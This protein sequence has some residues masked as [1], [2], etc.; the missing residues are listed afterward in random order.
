[1]RAACAFLFY[2]TGN[3]LITSAMENA[4]QQLQPPVRPRR[5]SNMEALRVLAMFFV[6]VVHADFSALGYPNISNLTHHPDERIVMSLV[7]YLSVVCVDVFVMISGWFGIRARAK[8]VARLLFQ[9]FFVTTIVIAGFAVYKGGLPDTLEKLWES[10]FGY[11]F[12]YAYLMLY[13]LSPVLNAFVERATQREFLGVLAAFFIVQTLGMRQL[14]GI[15]DHG[16]STLS[17]IGLYLL[18]R[19]LRL[20]VA[21]RET[22]PNVVLLLGYVG[23]AMLQL[24]IM[25][26]IAVGGDK[27]CLHEFNQISTNYTNP[28]I[29]IGAAFLLLFFSRLNFT[30]RIINWLAAGSLSVYVFHQNLLARPVFK[31]TVQHLHSEHG[32]LAFAG[33]TFLFLV[34]VYLMAVLIDQLR[35]WAWQAAEVG[36]QKLLTC[37]QARRKRTHGT[38]E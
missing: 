20:Y 29:I 4:Q 5:A 9:V 18:A 26:L 33:L 10:Y 1:M 19:Y 23:C 15:F 25:L 38:K 32:A 28:L 7:E 11:W 27:E 13:L 21:H 16:Y 37:R 12:V 8:G 3:S 31:E 30:S 14:S 22:V 2:I 17:F 6:L 36:T 34:G 24:I 35:A